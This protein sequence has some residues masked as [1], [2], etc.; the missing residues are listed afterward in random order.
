MKLPIKVTFRFPTAAE[1]GRSLGLKPA[2]IRKISALADEIA[3]KFPDGL[4]SAAPKIATTRRR[5]ANKTEPDR[6]RKAARPS[7]TATRRLQRAKRR[8]SRKV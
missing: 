6:D 2:E 7:A 4:A 5:P 8:R 1:T 3:E